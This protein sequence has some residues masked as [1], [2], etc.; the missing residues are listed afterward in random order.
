MSNKSDNPPSSSPPKRTSF[1]GIPGDLH[2]VGR[3]A[4]RTTDECRRAIEEIRSRLGLKE[5]VK[6]VV[7]RGRLYDEQAIFDMANRPRINPSNTNSR[8]FQLRFGADNELFAIELRLREAEAALARPDGLREARA[9]LEQVLLMESKEYRIGRGAIQ[10]GR[11]AARKVHV[12]KQA[13]WKKYQQFIDEQHQDNPSLSYAALTRAAAGKFGVSPKTIRRRT[14]APP[15]VRRQVYQRFINEQHQNYPSWSY[16][17]LTRAA[18][19]KFGVSQ[20][21]IRQYTKFPTS[22]R[23]RCI[24]HPEFPDSKQGAPTQVSR[25]R[26]VQKKGQ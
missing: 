14:E 6:R 17:V 5:M 8:S 18:A 19:G 4:C 15:D 20:K 25:I 7:A 2:L 22:P 13:Q 9:I 10:D 3:L 23:R 16:A 1:F 11:E 21:T 12:Q 24:I 26:K